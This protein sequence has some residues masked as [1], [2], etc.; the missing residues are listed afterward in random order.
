VFL[1]RFPKKRFVGVVVELASEK[2]AAG[3]ENSA[4]KKKKSHAGV[5]LDFCS[6]AYLQITELIEIGAT[7]RI[8]G[9]LPLRVG[10]VFRAMLPPL[11]EPERKK[12]NRSGANLVLGTESGGGEAECGKSLRG[13]ENC[14]AFGAHGG[15]EAS[16]FPRKVFEREESRKYGCLGPAA[17]M[18]A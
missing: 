10:E 13:G 11:T 16:V 7:M 14:P 8:A 4:K 9:L 17:K 6:G 12:Q 5:I 2:R 1:C 15:A 3:N 18:G